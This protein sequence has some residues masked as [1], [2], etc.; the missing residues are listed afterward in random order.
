MHFLAACARCDD[1]R[2]LLDV[3]LVAGPPPDVV[4]LNAALDAAAQAGDVDAAF[5]V[6]GLASGVTVPV[7]GESGVGAAAITPDVETFGGL[8]HACA[9]AGA[10]DD[11]AAVMAAM[12]DAG[13]APS[14]Q[15]YTSYMSALV[16]AE[17][18][19]STA[20]ADTGFSRERRTPPHGGAVAVATAVLDDMLAAGLAPTAVTYGV[21]LSAASA[22]GD[23]D[24]ALRFY[25]DAA[26]RGVA[27]TDECHAKLAIAVS[28]AGRPDDA[29]AA[30][31][32]VAHGRRGAAGPALNSLARAL[33]ARGRAPRALRVLSL[34]RTMGL[35]VAPATLDA[36]LCACATD[37][38]LADAEALAH[39]MADLGV[40]PS[41]A[42][43]S[44]LIVALVDAGRLAPAL[45]VYADMTRGELAPHPPAAEGGDPSARAARVPRRGARVR[46]PASTRSRRAAGAE[47]PALASLVAGMARAGDVEGAFRLYAGALRP[48]AVAVAA[49]TAS[50]ASRAADKL[51]PAPPPPGTERAW[52]ALIEGAC[53]TGRVDDALAAFDDWRA[54][55]DA[56]A[57]TGGESLT[58]SP[59]TL[60]FLEATCR[61]VDGYGDAVLSVCAAMRTQAARAAES[62][63]PA[64]AKPSHHVFGVVN[65]VGEEDDASSDSAD[66]PAAAP[67][68]P[69][70]PAA[71]AAAARRALVAA[72]EPGAAS[73]AR[74][75]AEAATARAALLARLESRRARE[76]EDRK[77]DGRSEDERA[78]VSLPNP[79]PADVAEAAQLNRPRPLRG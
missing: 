6:H 10:A 59:A 41:R 78:D 57:A 70:G 25:S 60:A 52:A 76:A 23:A 68:P 69:L 20:D 32:S 64:P 54:A 71:A 62:A 11:A 74:R 67:W 3:M 49:A 19:A 51:P 65:E 66:E 42:S 53:A 40:A 29:L 48:R 4:T 61:G 36:L 7:T 16:A 31:R 43:G 28:N 22:A 77:E 8:L 26:D 13:I 72:A 14:V 63:A 21:L 75:A 18:R 79:P 17:A 46:D 35:D 47:P 45:R 27:L 55:A 34:T 30:V 39:E 1:A 9:R 2:M 12:A 73:R 24:A 58:L 38:A 33:A 50:A 37:G 5:A 56:A 44:A 15:A